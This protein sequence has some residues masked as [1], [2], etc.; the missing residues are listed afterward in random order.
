M[1]SRIGRKIDDAKAFF[2]WANALS[3][4]GSI[5]LYNMMKQHFQEKA[6]FM[7]NGLNN[8]FSV[9]AFYHI[10]LPMTK[11]FADTLDEDM[12]KL[13]AFDFFNCSKCACPFIRT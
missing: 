13:I 7:V 8:D 11:N 2:N 6:D 10:Y 9:H 5:N 12:I 3:H 1:I 4:D